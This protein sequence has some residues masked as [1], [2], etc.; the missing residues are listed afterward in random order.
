MTAKVFTLSFYL[1]MI[2]VL[3]ILG[4]YA[5]GIR[6]TTIIFILFFIF[7][8]LIQ[9]KL[10]AALV[11]FVFMFSILITVNLEAFPMLQTIV[12]HTVWR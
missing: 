8:T 7:L 2:I 11:F 1:F 12:F 6:A 4:A 10:Y 5:S 9:A 3:I